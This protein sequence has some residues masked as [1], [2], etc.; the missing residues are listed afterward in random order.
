MK[1]EDVMTREVISIA[2]DATVLQAARLM[3]QHHISGLPVIDKVAIWSACCRKAISCAAA[4]PRPNTGARAGS[5][6]SWVPARIAAEYSHSHGSKVSEVMTTE[7]QTVDESTAARRHRRRD[8]A[9]AH[10]TRAGAMRRAGGR[11][12]HPF[13][14]DACDGEHGAGG[15]AGA[16]ND[17]ASHPREVAGGNPEGAM[18]ARG[19]DQCRGA[20]RRGRAVGRRSSTNAS[21]RRSKWPPKTF[22]ASRR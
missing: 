22:P 20:R 18:G 5:S 14:P 8:G 11:D 15:A 9:Q 19:H 10:Q 3:L 21:A 6:S 17:D 2:P 16:A 1:A 7:V 4:R 12:H 13:Q